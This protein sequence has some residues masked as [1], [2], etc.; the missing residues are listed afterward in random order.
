VRRLRG[1]AALAALL[2]ACST[3][4]GS[5]PGVFS[6]GA[7]RILAL[8]P[9]VRACVVSEGIWLGVLGEGFGPAA[10]WESGEH[11]VIFPPNPPGIQA[12]QVQLVGQTLFMRVPEGVASGTL[13]ID[14]GDLG[15]AEIPLTV[16]GT[17]VGGQMVGTICTS[18]PPVA[19]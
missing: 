1:L 6:T 17:G 8:D 11:A 2:V 13:I 12:E 15:R 10:P 5:I 3:G 16:E 14:A 18:N 4:V 7:L 9:D 19:P